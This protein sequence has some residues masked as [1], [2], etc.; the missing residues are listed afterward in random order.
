MFETKKSHFFHLKSLLQTPFTCKMELLDVKA[1]SYA[2]VSEG[3]TY[4]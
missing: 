3:S 1:V 2:S 4:V